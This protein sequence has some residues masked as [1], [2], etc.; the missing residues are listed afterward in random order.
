M[1]QIFASAVLSLFAAIPMAH[2]EHVEG[3]LK[4]VNNNLDPQPGDR[5]AFKGKECRYFG[6][7]EAVG[8]AVINRKRC[9]EVL[10]PITL[11]VPL[12]PAGSYQGGSKEY[13]A[14]A[15]RP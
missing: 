7:V 14:L 10:T 1:K 12:G 5:L 8:L 13:E 4:M 15:E 11:Y 9:S 3:N 2:A 6:K